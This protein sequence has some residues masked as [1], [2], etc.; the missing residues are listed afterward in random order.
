MRSDDQYRQD[1]APAREGLEGQVRKLAFD[2][3]E[4]EKKEQ[5]QKTPE[6]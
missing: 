6:A 1:H 3:A 2:T 5:V 4:K